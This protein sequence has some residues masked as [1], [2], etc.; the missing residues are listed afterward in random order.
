MNEAPLRNPLF[1]LFR[2]DSLALQLLILFPF[3]LLPFCGL[4]AQ[5]RVE[6]SAMKSEIL[7]RPV[8]FC[9]L[10]PPSYDR[11]KSRRFPI[12]YYLHGLGENEQSLISSGG[13][14]LVEDLRDAGKIG[15]FLIVVPEG[16]RSFYINSH[17]G[18]NRW[19]DFFLRE[20]M[21]A[22]ERKYRARTEK[23]SRGIAGT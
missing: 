3:S 5:S 9:A 7:R 2:A 1:S 12:L 19:E 22:M 23:S 13:W 21:R 8:N 4:S 16:G 6:C 15:E 11:D 20:F 18:K 17:D 10:L 14:N